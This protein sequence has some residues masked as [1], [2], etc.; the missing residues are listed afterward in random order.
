MPIYEYVCPKCEVVCEVLHNMQELDSPSDD[1]LRQI[2][3]D[4]NCTH[5]PHLMERRISL[6][7]PNKYQILDKDGK[8]A[9]LKKRATADY[10]SNTRERRQEMWKQA[11]L[12]EAG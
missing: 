7:A 2:T 4:G 8:R 1:T 6:P 3:C 10:N 11:G 12:R 9:M 5:P